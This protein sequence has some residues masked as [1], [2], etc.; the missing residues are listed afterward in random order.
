ML[1]ADREWSLA[2]VLPVDAQ[3]CVNRPVNKA[4]CGSLCRHGLMHVRPGV[5]GT[6]S[7]RLE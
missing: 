3:F 1:L 6:K 7:V 5:P 2:S 4:Q